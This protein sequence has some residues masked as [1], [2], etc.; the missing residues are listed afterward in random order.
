[1][2]ASDSTNS[3][4]G[5]TEHIGLEVEEK[6]CFICLDD[7]NDKHEPLVDSSLLRTCGCSF[8]VHP[9]CWNEWMKGKSDYD[10]PICRKKSLTMGKSPVPALPPSE[11]RD[12][13]TSFWRRPL[14]VLVGLVFLIGG[15]IMLYEMTHAKSQ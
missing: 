2:K 6:T 14:S 3:L 5:L 11:W 1:M 9:A 8:K 15:S 12:E 4:T 7:M 13:R 10:C